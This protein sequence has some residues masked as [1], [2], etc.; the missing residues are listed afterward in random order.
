MIKIRPISFVMAL[1]LLITMLPSC[2]SVKK[3]SNVVKADDPWYESTRFKLE[4]DIRQYEEEGVSAVFTSND[5]CYSLYCVS[6]DRWGS[7]RTVL[8]TYD[9]DGN[10]L[11]RNYVKCQD[12][13]YIMHVYSAN[14]DP[15]GNS[16]RVIIYYNSLSADGRVVF[17]NIDPGTG[18]LSDIKD[19]ISD[20]AKM[21]VKKNSS[22]FDVVSTGDYNIVVMLNDYKGGLV[23]NWQLL[24]FKD[25]EYITQMVKE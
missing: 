22:L 4:K 15:E 8:D 11:S 2:S 3:G 24:V 9:F 18:E 6:K 16:I 20:E 7:S 17:A 13:Y 23:F 25:G 19:L 14:A 12:G 5:R 10:M 1:I 21:A